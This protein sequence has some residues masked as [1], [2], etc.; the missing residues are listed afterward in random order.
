MSKVSIVGTEEQ[1]QW[2]YL[3]AKYDSDGDARITPAEYD[4][5]EKNFKGFDRNQDGVIDAADFEGGGGGMRMDPAMMRRMISPMILAR[6]FQADDDESSLT[7]NE[8]EPAFRTYDAN[9]DGRITR[10]E[11]EEQSETRG[12]RPSRRMDRF[13]TLIVSVAGEH[14]ETF[15]LE[16]L[17]DYFDSIEEGGLVK[18]PRIMGRGPASEGKVED[19]APNAV[20]K[21]APDFELPRLGSEDGEAP[22]K[23]SSFKGKRPVALIFGS[24]T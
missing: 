11:F 20:G 3:A 2:Q 8:L 21:A 24:Y 17:T 9:G 16:Q 10:E 14:A 1:T 15:D 13:G 7:R 19:D 22:V 18:A 23:L 6:Y 12:A 5:S 4:R